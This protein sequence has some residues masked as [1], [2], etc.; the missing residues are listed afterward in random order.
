[1]CIKFRYS[2]K[3]SSVGQRKI[4]PFITVFFLDCYKCCILVRLTYQLTG[5][6]FILATFGFSFNQTIYRTISRHFYKCVSKAFCPTLM[7]ILLT[8]HYITNHNTANAM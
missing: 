3:F 2:A 7:Y 4:L 8:W 6:N 1:M 5:I